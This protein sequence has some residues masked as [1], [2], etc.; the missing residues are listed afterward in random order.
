MIIFNPAD[1]KP[2]V[3]KIGRTVFNV[4][5][6]FCGHESIYYKLAALMEQEFR[7]D[8]MPKTIETTKDIVIDKDER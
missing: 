8:E 3:H 5:A 4:H 6:C 1:A 2:R 7:S